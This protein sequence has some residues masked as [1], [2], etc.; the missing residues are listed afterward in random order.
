M[1]KEMKPKKKGFSI[2]F[3][4]ILILFIDFV[5]KW[6]NL[7]ILTKIKKILLSYRA[8]V[9][10]VI[11]DGNWAI[12]WVGKYITESLKK[13]KL[14]NTELSTHYFATNKIIHFGSIN[15]LINPYG[16]IEL[17]ESNKNIVTWFHILPEDKRLKI[18]PF[19]NKKVDFLHTPSNFTKRKLIES[20]FD[21]KKI[22]VI[23]LGVDLS[24]FKKYNEKYK[25]LL[26]KKYNLPTDKIIIGSFQKDGVG[27]GE[28]L[29]P[30]L[31]KGPDVFC[32]VVKEIQEKFDIHIFL[33]GPARGYIKK[34][35]EEY[36]VPYTHIFLENYLDIVECYNS[37]DLYLV[38]SRAEGGPNALLEGMATGVPIV[39]TNVGMAADLVKQGI[40]GFITD[41]EDIDQ[42]YQFSY[43]V[44]KNKELKKELIRNGIKT[45]QK[46]N[47]EYVAKQYYQKIYSKL[48]D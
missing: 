25:T 31:I 46:Y 12:A 5:L 7:T 10:F 26:R 14:I 40:N 3:L 8:D 35:L 23:P 19:L 16:L 17:K 18:V 4:N 9:I 33:T 36:H 21:D 20:G 6:Y 24:Q 32:E 13:L 1:N 48:L 38:T 15:C 42:L 47:W 37:L 30:K 27:W 43:E 11:E 44:L 29:E 2:K 28:G 45:V 34:K 22:V 41:I 39:T